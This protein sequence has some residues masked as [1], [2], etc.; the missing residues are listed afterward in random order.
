MEFEK[1][2]GFQ[3]GVVLGLHVE[4]IP[5]DD[6]ANANEMIEG[7]GEEADDLPGEAQEGGRI[8][9]ERSAV[10]ARP[11]AR[12]LVSCRKRASDFFRAFLQ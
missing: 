12:V 2:L 5:D 4:P 1:V 3:C 6:V 10:A 11:W 9:D 8:E 7:E